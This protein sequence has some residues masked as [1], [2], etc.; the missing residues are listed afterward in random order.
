MGDTAK[1]VERAIVKNFSDGLEFK[2]WLGRVFLK[3]QT[4][5]F[6]MN[7]RQD[8]NQLAD[9]CLSDTF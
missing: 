4:K 5:L 7:P 2:F 9:V 1:M 8:L 3:N 6:A